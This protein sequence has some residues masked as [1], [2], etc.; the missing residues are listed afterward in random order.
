MQGGSGVLYTGAQIPL[1]GL[2]TWQ[3]QE[4]QVYAAVKTA[5]VT[6]YRHLD[7]AFIYGNEYEIGQAIAESEVQRED[8]F[9]TS[10]LWNTFHEPQHVEPV[11]DQSLKHLQLEYLDL[12]LMHCPYA[13]P[14][15]GFDFQPITIDQLETQGKPPSNANITLQTLGT[16]WRNLS[17]AAKSSTLAS[18]TSLSRIFKSSSKIALSALPS[19]K[20]NCTLIFLNTSCLPSAKRTT[21]TSLDTPLLAPSESQG[22]WK[23]PLLRILLKRITLMLPTSYLPGANSEGCSVI[24]K[25]SSEHHIQSNYQDIELPQEDMKIIDNLPTHKRFFDVFP[26]FED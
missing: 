12:Y 15:V 16:Q 21:S 10:K 25:S 13:Q 6:G 9:I 4:T 3:A 8:I 2:G 1:F 19:T 20:W 5:L 17:L 7:C 24:P 11:L 23:I 22:Y 14:F 26:V 18:P